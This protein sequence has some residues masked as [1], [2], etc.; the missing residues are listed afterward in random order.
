MRIKSIVT[1]LL[2]IPSLHSL[3]YEI[4]PSVLGFDPVHQ[5]ITLYAL[6]CLDERSPAAPENCLKPIEDCM[7]KLDRKE[8]AEN[9]ISGT[10]KEKMFLGK[11]SPEELAYATRWPDDPTEETGFRGGA[12][13]GIKM[14]LK[15]EE[16]LDK[17][18]QLNISNGLLCNSHFGEFQF[19]HAQAST[20]N[21][22]AEVTRNK[23]FGWAEFNYNVALGNIA[24][25]KGYCEYFDEHPSSISG[26]MKPD[27]F[28]YCND[29]LYW[30]FLP[31]FI[32]KPYPGYDIA[33]L[34]G[35]KCKNPF[36]SKTCSEDRINN[37]EERRKKTVLSATGA[38]LHLVQ[39]SFSQSH[40]E[41]GRCFQNFLMNGKRL[42]VSKIE[43]KPITMFT[44][45]AYYDANSQ[46]VSSQKDH[47]MSD[48]WPYIA[49]SCFS[50][51]RVVDDP[52]TASS[53]ILWH[54]SHRSSWADVKKDLL[55]VFNEMPG[56]T[57]SG[58]G[59]CY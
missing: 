57:I 6:D 39:D 37:A 34:Y 28:P 59:A 11:Y 42:P 18:K 21:E 20:V 26:I 30:G 12:K 19:W 25:D 38:L 50:K 36:S 56:K 47:D 46:S 5:A 45:Y 9:C 31:E 55:L 2:I 24:P 3:A 23:I 52:I 35:M 17:Q 29:R 15:C 48:S 7:R 41:R 54:I 27:T 44:N 14:K 43:C 53:K 1:I 13:F 51:E 16:I 58:R 10:R 8:T 33:T 4:G 32:V 40:A 22:T 49:E